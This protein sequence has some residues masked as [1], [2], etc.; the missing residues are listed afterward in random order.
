MVS[1]NT[2]ASIRPD[3]VEAAAEVFGAHGYERATL[4]EIA[5]L[6]GMQKGSLYYHIESKEQLLMAIHTKLFHILSLRMTEA[7]KSAESDPLAEITQLIR[8]IVDVIS[9]NRVAVRVVLRD[10]GSLTERNSRR[11][12]G[13]RAAVLKMLENVVRRL[14]RESGT[15][16]IGSALTIAYGVMGMT[17]FVSEWFNPSQHDAD[18]IADIFLKM[19]L[20][21]LMQP[22]SGRSSRA[23]LKKR[24]RH[25]AV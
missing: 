6:V 17:Y 1:D 13:N 21:G 25:L 10:R 5:A 11:I 3:I 23:G 22:T 7:I 15:T 2:D 24:G 16:N 4:D 14:C 18:T 9:T 20:D 19:L 8:A 12:E